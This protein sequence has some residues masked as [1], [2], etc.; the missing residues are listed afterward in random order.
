MSEAVQVSLILIRRLSDG[1]VEWIPI[2]NPPQ[3]VPV[4]PDSAYTVVDRAGYEAPKTLVPQ[5][6]GDNLVIEVQGSDAVV[7]DGFFTAEH[8]EF[9]P[10]TNLAAGEGP[11]SGAALTANSPELAASAPAEPEV[12]SAGHEQAGAATA[13]ATTTGTGGGSSPLLWV[14][15]AAGGLGL[16]A[17]AGGGGGS[18]G[19]SGGGGGVPPPPDTTPPQITSGATASAVAEN[20]G[21]GQV[22][23]TVTATDTSSVTYSL[24]AGGDASAFSINARTGA[25]TLIANPDFEAKPSYSFTVVA[26]DAA[27]N[28]AVQAVSLAIG[29]VADTPVTITSGASAAAIAENSAAGQVVYTA[30]AIATTGTTVTYSLKADGDAASFSIDSTTGAVTLTA[31]PNFEAKPSYSFT[32]IATDA[33]NNTAQQAVALGINNLDEVAPTITSATTAAINENGSAGQVVY[34]VT[35]TDTG[36]ISTGSTHYTL[37]GTD[38]AAFSINTNTGVVTLTGIPNFE[39]KA[40]YKFTVVATDAAGNNSQPRAVSLAINNLDEVAPTIT[41]GPTATAINENSAAGRVVYTVTSTDT[42]DVSTGSTHYTLSGTDAAAFA[43]NTNTGVVTLT[44]IPDFETKSSYHFTVGATDAAGNNSQPRAVSLAINNLDEVAPTITS[45]PT[46]TAINENSAAGRVVYTVTSTDTGDVST[47]S[48][49]YTL[50]GTDAAAFAINTNTGV[51]T[52]TG[53]PDFETKSSYNFTVGATD[54]AGNSSQPSAVSLAIN[55]V[56]PS[57]DHI[58]VT[59]AVGAQ[60]GIL[61]AGDTVQVTVTM[62]ENTV[63]NTAGGTPSIELSIGG[64]RVDAGYVSGSGTPN[65]VFAYTIQA[66]ENDSNGISVRPDSLSANGGSIQDPPGSAA[67]LAHGPVPSNPSFIVD[68]TAPTLSSSSP[69]NNA[70]DVPQ[71]ADIV[72]TFNENVLAG[73]GNITISGGIDVPPLAGHTIPVTDGSQVSISGNQLTIDPTSD[74][75]FSTTYSVRIDAGTITDAAG[76]PYAGISDITTLDFT[77]EDVIVSPLA[78]AQSASA[79]SRSFQSLASDSIDIR[80]AGSD[81]APSAD[82]ASFGA[83]SGAANLGSDDRIMVV[84]ADSWNPSAPANQVSIN[85]VGAPLQSLA[86][87]LEEHG[88]PIASSPAFEASLPGASLD[89]AGHVA[90]LEN[91]PAPILTS[92]GLVS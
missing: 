63:V 81:V 86:D 67:N 71:G 36:D 13:A 54:A 89:G 78:L 6:Q 43:I 12:W 30:A 61:N 37:S 18:G 77:T 39:T 87:S 52:L 44:G 35:S 7:L 4:T 17:L 88:L 56:P 84:S 72:L 58:A 80:G 20:S 14:G 64:D 91:I 90:S 76:N 83:W 28:T 57:V 8:A 27:N 49:H 3:H 92:Q 15:L 46:A 74:L 85:V 21:A 31:S 42:G 41:S 51:V 53:I 24:E 23:Y 2:Q 10:T 34:T 32:V 38:A 40:S 62:S 9:Y 19:E 55:N 73:S 48:T 59:G 69:A 5:R 33:A 79:D 47:G 22:V 45:G 66:G 68:T 82:A 25:V 1:R 29:N 65:L 75:V 60:N 11:F 16:A 50:S 26:T 70:T